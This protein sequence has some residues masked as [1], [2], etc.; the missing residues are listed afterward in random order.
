MKHYLISLL[1][2][3]L[4]LLL[5]CKETTTSK[6]PSST[7]VE[8]VEMLENLPEWSKDMNMYEVNIRQFTPEGTFSAFEKHIP[9]LQKMGVDI[10]WLMP[11]YPISETK[12]KGS[13]GSYYAVS[14]FTKV[15]PEFGTME[16]FQQLV[17]TIHESGMKIILDFVPNH[18]GW[19]HIWITEHPEY[20][21]KDKDGNIVD[22]IDPSTGESWGWTDVADLNFDNPD[23][24]KHM[25]SDMAFWIEKEQI[26][27]FRMD[28]AHGVPVSFW[29]EV[30]N[31]LTSV[32]KDVFMLAESEVPELRNNRYFQVDYGWEFH[33]ILN[34]IAK[35][36]KGP[37]AIK[38]WLNDNKK[39]YTKGW[40]IQFTSNHDENSWAGT[41]EER[42]GDAHDALSAL[43]FTIEGM[44]LIYGGQEE[45]LMKRLEFFEKDDIGFG[46]YKKADWYTKILAIK[47]ENEALWNGPFGGEVNFIETGENILIFSRQKNANDVIAIFNLSDKTSSV[48][49]DFDATQYNDLFMNKAFG[50]SKGES[51]ELGPWEYKILSN[52]K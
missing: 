45:P 49:I 19:D 15:N 50:K 29:E 14:D 26:D 1:C 5:S 21:T 47:K 20:Y 44:P 3:S 7:T 6:E 40:H 9:R 2:L 31:A 35:G 22:P 48:T 43:A 52:E 32:K 8:E 24:R 11:I 37:K 4:L 42:M 27:G 28:V 13:L 25:I 41:T 34:D 51:I 36:E 12:K 46:S 10:L 18:T 39:K 38:N 17:K 30:S 16:E 23:M 33:H